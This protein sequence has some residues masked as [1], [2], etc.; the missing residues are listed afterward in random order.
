[1]CQQ[2]F[3]AR[4][5]IGQRR[6]QDLDCLAGKV[7]RLDPE[8]GAG[9][10]GPQHANLVTNPFYQPAVITTFVFEL[11]L[12]LLFLQDLVYGLLVFEILFDLP[13]DKRLLKALDHFI[14]L[15]WVGSFV[16][17]LM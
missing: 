2:I 15:T 10:G 12:R 5:D 11:K 17:N 16:K 13:F 4:F 9:I 8:T 7:Y 6:A 14:W 3:G 1:M